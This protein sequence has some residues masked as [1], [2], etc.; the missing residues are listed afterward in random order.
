MCRF[1]SQI[2]NMKFNHN[3]PLSDFQSDIDKLKA[4]GYKPIAVSQMYLED[5]FVFETKNEATRAYRQFERDEKEEWIGEIVG[6]WYSKEDFEKTVKEY[7]TEND[8]YS[9]VLVHW[10]VS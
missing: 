9:K 4:N 1:S 2:K 7:E 6:W 10:L 8:G 3:R 5:T